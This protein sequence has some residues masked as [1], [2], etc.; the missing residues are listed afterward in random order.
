MT[1]GRSALI[2]LSLMVLA[3]AAPAFWFS[4]TGQRLRKEMM[5]RGEPDLPAKRGVDLEYLDKGEYLSRRQEQIDMLRG[6]DT[7]KPESRELAIAELDQAESVQAR[8]QEFNAPTAA[9]QPIGPAPIPISGTTA[10]SGRTTAIAVHPSN[11]NTVYA[12]TAQGGLYRSLDGGATWLPLMDNAATLAIGAIAI[13]PS[14]PSTIYVGTGESTQCGS[15]CFIGVGVYR[16]DNADTGLPVVTGPLNKNAANADVFSGRAISEVLVHPTDPNTIFVAT[17]SGIAG[18]GANTTGLPL[19]VRG[20]YRSTNAAGAAPTFTQLPLGI[21]ERNV[22]DLF[23]DPVDPNRIYAGVVGVSAGDGGVYSSGNALAPS[24]TFTQLLSTART[25]SQSRVELAGNN[26]GGTTTVYA[27]SGQNDGTTYKSVNAGGFTLV[28]NNSFCGGQCFYDIAIAVDPT[29]ASN[30]YLGG[31]PNLVLGRSNNGGASYAITPSSSGLHVDTQVV[32]LAPSNPSVIYFGSDGG[33]WKSVNAG[34]NWTTLNNSTY[35][36]TQFMSIA[37]HPTNTN[38]T[39][40]GTQDNGTELFT[41][42]G[43]WLNSDGGDGGFAVID[44]TST[45]LADIVAYH[46]Y[47]N[48]TTTQIGFAKHSA[49]DPT[50]GDPF[51]STFHGCGT[52]PSVVPN[53]ITC[54]DAVL[55]YAPMVNGPVAVDSA[56]KNTLYFGTDKLYRSSNLGLAMTVASQVISG[57]VSAI[58]ISPQNDDIRLIGTDTG[59]VYY[60]NTAGATTMTDITGAIPPRYVGRIAISPVNQNTAYVALNG[61]GIANQHVMKTTNLGSAVPTWVNSGIGIPDVPTNALVIDP[62]NANIIYA[63]TDI[64]VFRSTDSGASWAPFGTGLPRVAV[65]GMSIQPTS[66][67]LRIATHGKGMWQIPAAVPA[68]TVSLSGRVLTADGRGLRRATVKLTAADGSVRTTQTGARGFYQFDNLPG[69]AT[70]TVT[71]VSRRY[72]YEPRTVTL[73]QSVSGFDLTPSSGP[74]S[75]EPRAATRRR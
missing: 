49:L 22:T 14:N 16:I 26:V 19:P 42:A 57:R 13:A 8:S 35:S 61:Y 6:F 56:G 4:S 7:A 34:L 18:I 38:Y 31:S 71:V 67:L 65:F 40:G 24:P 44:Q 73:D 54:T 17:T 63:G 59:R 50:T 2:L 46:T 10:Y 68:A 27:A 70:Y 36:A 5:S 30:V 12:G 51:W 11:P 15:G 64:G 52:D 25:G 21:S 48:Q 66:R 29:N 60:S 37:T 53:G 47:F 23:M 43:A 32:T 75:P 3:L 20:V 69:G 74:Q 9:W 45:T 33:I 28:L 41:P 72:S 55:F 1:K 62:A 39:L 58:G